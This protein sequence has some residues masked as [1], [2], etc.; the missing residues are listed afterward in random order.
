MTRICVQCPECG[1]RFREEVDVPPSWRLIIFSNIAGILFG[2][3]LGS[4][5]REIVVSLWYSLG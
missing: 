3:G 1:R 2:I 5:I 4:L